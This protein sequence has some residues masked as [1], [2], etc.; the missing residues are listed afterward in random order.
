VLTPWF[1]A[2]VMLSVWPVATA[3]LD[4]KAAVLRVDEDALLPI[5]RLDLPPEDR[6]FAGGVLATEDNQTT[7][8]FLGTDYS[9]ET[10]AVS[11]DAAPAALDRLLAEGTSIVVVMADDDL[12]LALADHAGEDVLVLNALAS[13]D[14]LRD[15]DCRANMLHVAP[16][17]AMR[18]DA[19]AQYLM[20]KKWDEWV[21]IQ[22]SH[23]EDLALAAAYR[24]SAQKFG[25]KIVEERGFD[26][27][28]GA[29]RTDTGLVLVQRQIPLFTQDMK[30]H[31]VVVVADEADVFAAHLPYHTWEPEL[32]VGSAGLRPATWMPAHEAW[33]ATQFQT[34]FEKLTK[35]YAREDDYQVW[36]ALRVVG[37]AVTRTGKADPASI[38]EYALGDEFELG[39]F[40][41]Q[42]VTFRPWNGQ[43]RQPILLTDGRV[44]VSVSPQD[45]YLH[46]VSPLDTLGIDQPESACTAFE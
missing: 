43:L 44:T 12:T 37:E 15:A 11:P 1:A 2:F 20:W 19:L 17:R 10:V 22:G 8:S 16:S 45:G 7:G 35:R 32:I 14:R 24:R 30:R 28:G 21:L 38:R 36:L 41:G 25:A 4:V 13:G 39:A 23:P 18:T 9:L 27:T 34:R 3:A 31:D 46:Q 29:R 26:D 42:P 40:K 6:G 5:S 33:G